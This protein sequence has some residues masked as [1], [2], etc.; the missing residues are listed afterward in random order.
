MR[1]LKIRKLQAQ[2][3]RNLSSD[4]IS[5]SSGIN[6]ILG[7][8][9]NGKTNILEAIYLL[10]TRKSFRKNARFPQYLG[11][12]GEN[13]EI[14]LSAAFEEGEQLIPYSGKLREEGTE[15]YLEGRPTKKKLPVGVIFVDPFGGQKFYTSASVRRHWFDTHFSQL[16]LA[17]A[18]NLARYQAGLKF[19]NSLLSLRPDKFRQQISALDSEMAPVAVELTNLRKK[20]LKELETFAGKI[21]GEIFDKKHKLGLNLSGQMI[22]ASVQKYLHILAKN[23]PQDEMAGHSKW[24]IHRDDYTVLFDG[25]DSFSYCSLG[26]QKMA[27]LGLLFAYIELFRYRLISSP[28]VLMDDVSGELDKV[29][30]GRLVNYL[31]KRS[32][33]VLITTA[34]EKFGEELR[35]IERANRIVVRLGVASQS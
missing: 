8:N 4:V 31:E 33:Q 17:Y 32:F 11:I 9:G 14:Y 3:F 28:I 16:D 23:L 24:G 15:W 29:R 2:N 21:F 7:E 13:S 1:P 30:W 19:R 6:C 20:F 5:F 35:R 25:L 26:Q 27:Y 22:N 34:N 12:D 10:I 18:K